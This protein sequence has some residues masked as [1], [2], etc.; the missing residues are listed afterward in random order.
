MKENEHKIPD[1]WISEDFGNLI[2]EQRKSKLKVSDATNF[3]LY[4]FFTSGEATLLHNEKQI[5]GE[6][7]FLATGG[8]ANVKYFKGDVAYSTDTY[9][10]GTKDIINTKFLFYYSADS[11]YKC[12]FFLIC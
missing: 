10:I 1:G 4:P 11:S 5:D 12:N 3:G 9:A 7:I 2:L 8:L 6:N